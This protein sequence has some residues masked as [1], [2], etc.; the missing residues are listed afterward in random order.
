GPSV[1]FEHRWNRSFLPGR[2]I[3]MVAPNANQVHRFIVASDGILEIRHHRPVAIIEDGDAGTDSAIPTPSG[4]QASPA[5]AF[6]KAIVGTT[7]RRPQ[8]VA[9]SQSFAGPSS[10]RNAVVI[11]AM[12]VAARRAMPKPFI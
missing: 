6:K 11:Q 9:R 10:R 3:D 12:P 1:P 7:G 2:V 4:Y 5:V 8:A